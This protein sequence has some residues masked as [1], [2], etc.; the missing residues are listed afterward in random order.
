VNDEIVYRT[1]EELRDADRFFAQDVAD[2][3]LESD[4]GAVLESLHRLVDQ[5]RLV[6][7]DCVTAS[8]VSEDA[9][10]YEGFRFRLRLESRRGR[11]LT[12]LTAGQPGV[13][14]RELIASISPVAPRREL[15]HAHE[16]PSTERRTERSPI[17]GVGS[18]RSAR[19]AH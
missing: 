1:A 17:R 13:D 9:A 18:A 16:L 5:G 6:H 2:L 11:S 3:M 4:V 12:L 15:E 7:L 14:A 19:P 8:G 10:E